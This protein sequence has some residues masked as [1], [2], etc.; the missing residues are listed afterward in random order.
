MVFNEQLYNRFSCDW[1][2]LN[3]IELKELNQQELSAVWEKTKN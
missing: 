1:F 2:K 3:L